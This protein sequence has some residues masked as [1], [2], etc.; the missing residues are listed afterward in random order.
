MFFFPDAEN[1]PGIIR[2]GTEYYDMTTF[3]ILDI[4]VRGAIP[5]RDTNFA[6]LGEYSANL[7]KDGV[8]NYPVIC[9]LDDYFVG[10]KDLWKNVKVSEGKVT[11]ITE[12]VGEREYV[13]E[14]VKELV[15]AHKILDIFPSQQ[16]GLE[17]AGYINASYIVT[18]RS[19]VQYREAEPEE[20]TTIPELELYFSSLKGKTEGRDR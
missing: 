13:E 14:E 12:G 3:T 20:I 6:F 11:I 16:E 15:A 2:V 5:T 10:L 18:S 1:R 7:V 17:N 19:S 8:V 4:R 9:A